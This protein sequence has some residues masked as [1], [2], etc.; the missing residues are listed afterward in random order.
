MFDVIRKATHTEPTRAMLNDL[1]SAAA[2]ENELAPPR[3]FPIGAAFPIDFGARVSLVRDLSL[4]DAS[5][6]AVWDT[7]MWGIHKEAISLSTNTCCTSRPKSGDWTAAAIVQQQIIN[8]SRY[9]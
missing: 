5:A 7:A 1:A 6:S 2:L 3:A 9:N 8:K 4:K